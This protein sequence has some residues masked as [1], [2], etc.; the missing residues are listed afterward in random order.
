[1][2][3]VYNYLYIFRY[4]CS[5]ICKFVSKCDACQF[6]G[7]CKP[8][9]IHPVTIEHAIRRQQPT[10]FFSLFFSFNSAFEIPLVWCL[11]LYSFL[12]V[13][14]YLA[15]VLA[16]QCDADISTV[17]ACFSL[18]PRLQ[19]SSHSLT[20][21]LPPPLLFSRYPK[22]PSPKCPPTTPPIWLLPLIPTSCF[23]LVTG[24]TTSLIIII[25]LPQP[26]PHLSPSSDRPYQ[27][28]NATTAMPRSPN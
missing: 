2:P 18:T 26:P 5:F 9:R 11:R 28:E 27:E 13:R 4:L 3:T 22:R 21:S 20:L 8:P 16:R 17:A 15:R 7:A 24:R 23:C 1:M 14:F 10:F 19:I 6:L 25:C 12:K